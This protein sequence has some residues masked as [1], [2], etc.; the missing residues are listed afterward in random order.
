[1]RTLRDILNLIFVPSLI[2]A[3]PYILICLPSIIGYVPFEVNFESMSPT[4]NLSELVYYTAAKKSDFNVGDLVLYDDNQIENARVFHRIV[5]I[6]ADGFVTKADGNDLDDEGLLLYE[7]V[8]GKIADMKIPSI[9]P[10]LRFANSNLIVIYASVGIW[11]VYGFL[12]LMICISDF[13]KRVKMGKEKR[14]LK[15][16]KKLEELKAAK[17]A[18]EK[19]KAAAQTNAAA[20]AQP[21]PTATPVTET[22]SSPAATPVTEAQPATPATATVTPTQT[23]PAQ[24]AT[25]APA[26]TG[27]TPKA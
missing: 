13:S 3:F 6:K 15:K 7:D 5:D 16:Q 27:E 1:M 2:I 19:A 22:Q 23:V 12:S 9:G 17:E 4:Y 11:G 20:S 8:I 25:P 26:N 21:V 14:R 24:P 10:Y 18:E